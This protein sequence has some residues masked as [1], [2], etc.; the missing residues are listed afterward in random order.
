[1]GIKPSDIDTS[2]HFFSAGFV[3]K[4]QQETEVSARYIVKLCQQKDAWEPFTLQDI[5]DQANEQFWFNGLRMYNRGDKNGEYDY[6]TRDEDGQFHI[7]EKFV[8]CCAAANGI[9]EIPTRALTN[10]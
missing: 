10:A 1:M 5:D 2:S 7:T 6:I 8:R 3:A 4:H 9:V